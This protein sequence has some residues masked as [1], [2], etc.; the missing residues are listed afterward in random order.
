MINNAAGVTGPAHHTFTFF[1]RKEAV[2]NYS[3]PIISVNQSLRCCLIDVL[4]RV[5]EFCLRLYNA[6]V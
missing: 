6:R 5:P 2:G 3:Q 4:V 1:L